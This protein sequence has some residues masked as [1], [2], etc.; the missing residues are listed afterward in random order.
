MLMVDLAGEGFVDGRFS[1]W[2]KFSRDMT[3]RFAHTTDSTTIGADFST[4][5]GH[6]Q[7]QKAFAGW[8]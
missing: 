5:G 2:T 6:K 3:W 8:S 7:V 4:S 1:C